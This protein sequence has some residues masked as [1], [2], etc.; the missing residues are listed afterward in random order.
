MNYPLLEV[1][2]VLN[3]SQYR[4]SWKYH[5]TQIGLKIKT[6][7]SHCYQPDPYLFVFLKSASH[8]HHTNYGKK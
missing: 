6:A 8:Q 4:Q 3:H 2:H 1:N 5:S 7:G